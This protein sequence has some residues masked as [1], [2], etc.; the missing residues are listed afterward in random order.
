M[1]ID[2]CEGV[3]EAWEYYSYT[4]GW[5]REGFIAL[6]GSSLEARQHISGSTYTGY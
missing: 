1:V 2:A 6:L 3:V 5:S 4:I